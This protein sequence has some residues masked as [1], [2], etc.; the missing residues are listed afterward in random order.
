MFRIC[1]YP[2]TLS[3]RLEHT[4]F[5]WPTWTTSLQI[6]IDR[7]QNHQFS[8]VTSKS[9]G[10][11]SSVR[12]RCNNRKVCHPCWSKKSR[13]VA[14]SSVVSSW[15]R[16]FVGHRF[17]GHEWIHKFV[18]SKLFTIPCLNVI[19][20]IVIFNCHHHDQTSSNHKKHK[21]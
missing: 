3:L 8:I 15:D 17:G 7:R 2:S 9:S 11:V 14:S 12:S 19:I 21:R 13:E 10:L 6:Q 1:Y 20:Q 5:V 18:R 16:E 4:N